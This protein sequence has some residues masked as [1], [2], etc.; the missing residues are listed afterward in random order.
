MIIVGSKGFAKE[1]LEILQQ[2]DR[3][4]DLFFFD[5]VSDDSDETLYGMFAILRDT[6]AV[7]EVLASRS[8]EFTLGVGGP[9][10][11]ARMARRFRGLGG[12]LVSTISPFA[13]V[14]SFGTVIMP[15]CSIMTGV[16]ITN[17][18]HVGEGVLLNLN[19]TV[20][21]DVVIG[22]YAELSPGVHVSGRVTIGRLS[23]IG[24]GAAILPGVTIGNRVT[25]GAGAVV[26]KDVGSNK[27]VVG[28]PA[29]VVR[30]LEPVDPEER[31]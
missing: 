31:T 6:Y 1:V 18:V 11:R 16:V 25:V 3:V 29:K 26:T 27:V 20:G 17:D 8:S 28:V 12:E 22:D 23:S 2:L 15:G 5:D 30:E 9:A 21:H 10:I 7:Q 14:G 24:S 13:H 19:C 4:S